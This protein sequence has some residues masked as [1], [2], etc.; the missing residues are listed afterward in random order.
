MPH[1]LFV[2]QEEQ[3]KTIE[4]KLSLVAY[5]VLF[6][7]SIIFGFLSMPTEMGLTI[8]AG[9]L[10]L[11]FLNI[12]KIKR[13]KGA[14]FEAEMQEKIEAI[15]EKE[16]EPEQNENNSSCGFTFEAYGADEKSRKVIKSLLNPKFTWRYLG[17]ISKESGL[18]KDESLKTLNWLLDNKLGSYTKGEN[19]RLWSLTAK[20]RNVFK[21]IENA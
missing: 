5:A 13:F 7:I 3:M 16:T 4:K 1:T 12:D 18:S 9:S 11:A 15:I 6:G 17:G 2:M 10:G 14:G 19:G 8:V 21:N 20:G